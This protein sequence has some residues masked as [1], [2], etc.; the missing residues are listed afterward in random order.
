MNKIHIAVVLC[1]ALTALLSCSENLFGSSSSGDCGKDIECL[2][3]EAENQFRNG[4]YEKAYNS[5]SKIVKI[6]STAS[7]GYFG[8]AKSGLWMK[9]V[10]PFDM[11][12]FADVKKL[13][14]DEGNKK[15]PFRDDSIKVQNRYYQGTTLSYKALFE[16]NRRDS[17]TALYEL[18]KKELI[19]QAGYMSDIL[20]EDLKNF[21]SEFS[22][23]KDFPLSDREY[24]PNSY[25]GGLAVF[26]MAKSVLGFFDMNNDDCITKHPEIG[27][28][29][30]VDFPGEIKDEAA[31]LKWGCKKVDGTFEIDLPIGLN[32]DGTIDTELILKIL[33]E[34]LDDFYL[35]QLIE[36]T[37]VPA[38]IE[39]INN[40]INE[41]NGNLD[42]VKG[43]LG[44]EGD[45]QEE[46]NKYND[47]VSFFKVG[48]R[49]DE[50]G[51]GCIDE[52]LL[53]GQ[54]NDGDG[55][56]GE[57]ARLASI[58]PNNPSN[59]IWGK[60]GANHVMMFNED[61]NDPRNLPMQLQPPQHICN[62]IACNKQTTLEPDTNGVIT[63][64]GFTQIQEPKYWTTDN[65]D[66]KLKVAKDTDRNNLKYNLQV[67]KAT[68]GGCWLFYDEA[69][70]Q[71][72]LDRHKN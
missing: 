49:L 1:F 4:N 38:D 44:D 58:D 36:I 59:P 72:W 48:T 32:P 31:W 9:G 18:H 66:L 8:M 39:N 12:R 70:F 47:Y 26:T 63:V 23:F 56:K 60:I 57:D 68:V 53:N 14:D 55:I 16:L 17:L 30:G 2:R 62:D 25:Y 54:D 22:P 7:V 3:L 41:F 34:K 71:K 65:R 6:D 46:M 43:I 21:R 29:P 28:K 19:G 15:I 51:D 40:K 64:I 67:R 10:N 50:D 13:E 45:W 61:P 42:E 5:Y 11:F 69:Q 20:R 52:E 35:K 24:K 33:N 27:G 37:N